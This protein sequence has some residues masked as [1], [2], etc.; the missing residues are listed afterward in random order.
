[1]ISSQLDFEA[2][3]TN[4]VGFGLTWPKIYR[5]RGKHDNYYTI[6]VINL[7]STCHNIIC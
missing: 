4:F 2:A 6:N 7:S 3:N 5:T 1:M